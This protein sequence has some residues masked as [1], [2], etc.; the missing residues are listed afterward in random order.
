MLNITLK[1]YHTR[2]QCNKSATQTLNQCLL[3]YIFIYSLGNRRNYSQKAGDYFNF[4]I[5]IQKHWKTVS[6][7]STSKIY[8]F[9]SWCLRSFFNWVLI[10]CPS[11]WTRKTPV[12]PKQQG[13][14]KTKKLDSLK[15]VLNPCTNVLSCDRD[16]KTSG[17]NH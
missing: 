4:F 3:K 16:I 2:S 6:T 14:K 11:P 17:I 10:T 12:Q 15:N 5:S 1:C 13:Q 7:S 9:K 8:K